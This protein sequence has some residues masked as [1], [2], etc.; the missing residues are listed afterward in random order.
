MS[1]SLLFCVGA[2]DSLLALAV[3]QFSRSFPGVRGRSLCGLPSCARTFWN[4]TPRAGEE[5]GSFP[6]RS[7]PQ[8]SARPA[9]GGS[10]PTSSGCAAS[11]DTT[12]T[13]TRPDPDTPRDDRPSCT[14]AC[15]TPSMC[16]AGSS[17]PAAPACSPAHV[18]AHDPPELSLAW[19]VAPTWPATSPRR[20]SP[21]TPGSRTCRP[22]ASPDPAAPETR[23][24]SA[25]TSARPS[26]WTSLAPDVEVESEPPR[27]ATADWSSGSSSNT[28]SD[29]PT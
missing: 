16:R 2:T 27:P 24:H 22:P 10:T 3:A 1:G 17:L 12:G 6:P 15:R 14:G 11:C 25:G 13:A 4:G 19:T 18:L 20:P 28:P 8:P 23:G 7:A 26:V 9:M 29:S 21:S 5:T